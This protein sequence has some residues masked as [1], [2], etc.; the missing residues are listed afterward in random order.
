VL[1]T[2]A[3]DSGWGRGVETGGLISGTYLRINHAKRRQGIADDALIALINDS[4]I[5]EACAAIEKWY[6]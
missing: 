3:S 2:R 5:A 6:A 1:I 4:E